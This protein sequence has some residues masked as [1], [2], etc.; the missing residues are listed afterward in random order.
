M[1]FALSAIIIINPN[2]PNSFRPSLLQL[3]MM[4]SEIVLTVNHQSTP[5]DVADI[6]DDDTDT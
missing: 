5:L 3:L 6:K 4:I 2:K 1:N